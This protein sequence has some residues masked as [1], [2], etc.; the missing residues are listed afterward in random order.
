MS[1]LFRRTFAA[2]MGILVVL[3]AI[4]GGALVAG[5]HQSLSTWS[6]RRVTAIEDAARLILAG[7]PAA[8]HA[9]PQDI[10][11]FVYRA[12]GT[13]VASNRGVGRQRDIEHEQYMPVRVDGQ[14][15]GYYTVGSVQF[16]DDAANQAL[17]ES[18]IRAAV[19]GALVASAVAAA[20]AFGFARWLSSPAAS[21]AAGIDS[22]ARGSLGT[23]IP[24]EGAAEIG[25]SPGVV[26]HLQPD[27]SQRID[28]IKSSASGL[29]DQV[30]GLFGIGYEGPTGA[31]PA[32][33]VTHD[34]GPFTQAQASGLA[35]AGIVLAILFLSK[36]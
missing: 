2:F 19:A 16:R 30:K 33:D 15:V 8:E 31:Q 9:I 23:P 21:V 11:V 25:N 22:I 34:V 35:I 18:L 36:K 14:L 29:L 27:K 28:T 24:E 1:S 12:D 20:A 5:Y 10:P 6:A 26:E 7:R 3:L 17:T 4:L 13:L 32:R